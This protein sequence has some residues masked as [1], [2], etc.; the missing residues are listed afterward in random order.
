MI[1]LKNHSGLIS[2]A[3]YPKLI[4]KGSHDHF[5]DNFTR[6]LYFAIPALGLTIIFSKPALFALKPLYSEV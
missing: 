3:L 6:L 1:L 2:Q 4:A 5:R